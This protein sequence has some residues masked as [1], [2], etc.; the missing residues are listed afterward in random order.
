ME[1]INNSFKNNQEQNNLF[2][3]NNTKNVTIIKNTINEK[4]DSNNYIYFN[5]N[6]SNILTVSIAAIISKIPFT[7]KS[8]I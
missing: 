6:I 5:Y 4:K 2:G 1:I 7:K 8:S 3:L